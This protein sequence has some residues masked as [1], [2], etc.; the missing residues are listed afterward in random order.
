MTVDKM[1]ATVNGGVGPQL[2][3]YSDLLWQLALQPSTPLVKPT[4]DDLNQALKLLE[5]QHLILQEA[6]KLPTSAPTEV[7]VQKAR[8][9]LARHFPPGELAA[10]MAKVGLTSKRLDQIISDRLA[11]V[12]YLDFRFRAFVL[13]TQKDI[14][15]YYTEVYVP[16]E[17]SHDRI[18]R[19]L[20][21][22]GADIERILT[23]SKIESETD[24]FID[25]LRDRAEIVILNPV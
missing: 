17:R 9:E 24:A 8:D 7:D 21:E 12:K 13:I 11:M 23:E 3:T 25:S 22:A 16:Q 18:V 6:E 15:D 1:V 20:A 19:T 2:I 10:R 5:D 4:S 14:S